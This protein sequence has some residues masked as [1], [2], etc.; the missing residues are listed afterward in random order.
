MWSTPGRQGC[1]LK[2][3]QNI[4]NILDLLYKVYIFLPTFLLKCLQLK[5]TP[6]REGRQSLFP[7]P[8]PHPHPQ[9]LQRTQCAV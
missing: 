6:G 8:T 2:N 7:K 5:P 3:A 1:H 9:L 4:S